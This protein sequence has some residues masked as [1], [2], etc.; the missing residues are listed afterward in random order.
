MKKTLKFAFMFCFIFI[1]LF[2]LSACSLGTYSVAFIN[3]DGSLVAIKTYSN[4]ESVNNTPSPPSRLGFTFT[5]WKQDITPPKNIE[6]F[7][8]KVKYNL[9][10]SYQIN[11]NDSVFLESGCTLSWYGSPINSPEISF[12]AGKTK[13][14]LIENLVNFSNFKKVEIVSSDNTH[15]SCQSFKVF[16]KNGYIVNEN[17][18]NSTSW[19]PTSSDMPTQGEYRFVIEIISYEF[20]SGIIKLS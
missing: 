9:Y 13:H 1:I 17:S 18:I 20:K 16:D 10:A 11:P 8:E 7:N 2:L 3:Y 5:G 6:K 4:G 12:M 15:F 14:I 19:S